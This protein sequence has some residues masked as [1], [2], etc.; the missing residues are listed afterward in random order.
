MVSH[1]IGDLE[2]LATYESFRQAIDHLCHLYD[3]EPAAVVHDLHPEYLSTKLADSLELPL[4]RS[5]APPRPRGLLPGRQRPGRHRGRSR[6][7]RH[8]LRRRRHPLGRRG[9]RRRPR[10]RAPGWVV[11]APSSCPAGWR[12]SGSRGAWRRRGSRPPGVRIVRP[13][14]PVDARRRHDV[15]AVIAAG[16]GPTTTSIGRLFDAIGSLVT[17]RSV[18]T[19]EAQAAIELEALARRVSRRDAPPWPDAIV[20][21]PVDGLAEFDPRPL[22][23][24]VVDAAATPASPPRW[25]RRVSTRRSGGPP[26]PSPSSAARCQGLGT[27]ALTGG[28]FQNV[29]LTEVVAGVLS[30]AGLEVLRAPPRPAQ[31]RRDQCRA[32]CSR[33]DPPLTVEPVVPVRPARRPWWRTP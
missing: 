26:P 1:H 31:R 11:S 28:A 10:P 13:L 30:H 17:G 16:H 7:R 14:P 25:S 32:G 5:A 27:V 20:L 15:A 4:D 18:A 12:P 8:R 22:V 9:P 21:A 24:A 23:A 3:I 33:R 29:R 19:Y 2:H 6:V